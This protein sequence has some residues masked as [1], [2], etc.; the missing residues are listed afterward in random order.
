MWIPQSRS[1][2]FSV[3]FAP[4]LYFSF[5]HLMIPLSFMPNPTP[6]DRHAFLC[7]YTRDTWASTTILA[8][9][10]RYWPASQMWYSVCYY[11]VSCALRSS[12]SF[13]RSTDPTFAYQL[14]TSCEWIQEV[15]D[16]NLSE[17]KRCLLAAV[18][19]PKGQS[20][21]SSSWMKGRTVSSYFSLAIF[22]FSL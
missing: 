3:F 4:N 8:L 7:G 2:T 10:W 11:P 21:K 22:Q 1:I 14:L 13:V 9:Q 18:T 6:S 5:A 20:A 15:A 17:A 12:L 19:R 16:G